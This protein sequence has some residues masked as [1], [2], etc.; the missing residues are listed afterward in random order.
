MHKPAHPGEILK[1]DI[2]EALHLNMESVANHLG[3]S[4]KHLSKV[5]N[6]KNP[7]SAQLALRLEQAFGAP[8]AETWLKMQAQYDAWVARQNDDHPVK[9]IPEAA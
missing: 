7:I 2:I 1:E 3:Y 8:T 4:R 5:C 9:R 6:Q